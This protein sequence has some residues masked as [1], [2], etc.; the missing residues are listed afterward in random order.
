VT[1]N[2]CDLPIPGAALLGNQS[3]AL[4]L[5]DS[6]ALLEVGYKKTAGDAAAANAASPATKAA[7][8]TTPAGLLVQQQ[9]LL[10]CMTKPVD[11]K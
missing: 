2:P 6:G 10:V 9:C 8:Q 3:F 5:A 4:S 7:E 11:C 1:D